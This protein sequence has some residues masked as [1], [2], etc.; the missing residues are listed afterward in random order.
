KPCALREEMLFHGMTPAR[1]LRPFGPVVLAARP[2]LTGPFG[3][4]LLA[5]RPRRFRAR[6][7]CARSGLVAALARARRGFADFRLRF[8][9]AGQRFGVGLGLVGPARSGLRVRR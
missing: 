9:P 3:A 4:V 7:A 2:R 5:A 1:F 8:L 6:S